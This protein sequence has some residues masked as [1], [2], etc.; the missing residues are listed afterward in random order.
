MSKYHV[1]LLLEAGLKPNPPAKE[2]SLI[3]EGGKD[4]TGAIDH[5]IEFE[6]DTLQNRYLTFLIGQEVYGIEVKYVT[7]IVGM[8]TITEMPEF[9]HYV[10]GIMNLRGK[11][12]AVVDVRLRFKKEPKEYDDR[13]CIIVVDFKGTSIGLI[14][15]T[16]SE[17]ITIPEEDVTDAPQFNKSLQNKCIRKIGKVGEDIRLLVDCEKLISDEDLIDIMEAM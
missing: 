3:S 13:T 16:V 14:V 10:K 6:G 1:V 5:I 12:I 2:T 15:D 7:E 9:P 4:M 11:I 8:Q 17:V